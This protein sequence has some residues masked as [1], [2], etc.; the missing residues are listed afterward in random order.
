[1]ID[2]AGGLAA[3]E[4]VKLVDS[5]G[6]RETAGPS[7]TEAQPSARHDAKVVTEDRG[8]RG[9][10]ERVAGSDNAAELILGNRGYLLGHFA[11][12]TNFAYFLVASSR[13]TLAWETHFWYFAA[14][15]VNRWSP[16]PN[17]SKK[18][19]VRSPST[20]AQ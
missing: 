13:L 15:A 4:L 3:V 12:R 20:S 16:C 19:S 8:V 17:R 7:A 1:M 2:P 6:S 18:I 10:L 14:L 11:Y 5:P 9:T